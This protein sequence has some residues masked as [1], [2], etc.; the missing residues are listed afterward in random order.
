LIANRLCATGQCVVVREPEVITDLVAAWLW[1]EGPE[2]RASVQAVLGVVAPILLQHA[3][4]A[5]ERPDALAI[6]KP[7]AWNIRHH[8][9]LDHTLPSAPAIFVHRPALEVV[10]SM[11]ARPPVWSSLRRSSAVAHRFFPSIPEHDMAL[12][13]AALYAHAWRSCVEAALAIPE[14]RLL[15]VS[16]ERLVRAPEAVLTEVFDHFDQV[17][18]PDAA[19][20]SAAPMYYS[21]ANEP[22]D[23]GGRHYRA[24]LAPALAEDVIAITTA[25]ETRLNRRSEAAGHG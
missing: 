11:M 10:A 17:L 5:S 19:R 12:T 7:T 16:Y 9:L 20:R 8:A 2:E 1:A 15:L 21:K 6:L 22:F 23:P 3:R 4:L 25:A 13:E 24:P 18:T 14:G